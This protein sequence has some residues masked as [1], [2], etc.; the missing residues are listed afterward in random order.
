MSAALT[1]LTL[2]HDIKK[3]TLKYMSRC[4]LSM[5]VRTIVRFMFLFFL[6]TC[7]RAICSLQ[8]AGGIYALVALSPSVGVYQGGRFRGNVPIRVVQPSTLEINS[9][10]VTSLDDNNFVIK[11]ERESRKRRRQAT[12]PAITVSYEATW[13]AWDGKLRVTVCWRELL[14]L[15]DSGGDWVKTNLIY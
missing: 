8:S 13:G 4:F 7:R 12:V 5:Q 11:E 14:Y 6:N 9:I 15:D 3:T 2:Y 10:D 1:S